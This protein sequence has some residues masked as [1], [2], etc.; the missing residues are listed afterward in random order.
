MISSQE[1]LEVK[2]SD[3]ES[4]IAQASIES[5]TYQLRTDGEFLIEFFLGDALEFPVPQIHIDCWAKMTNLEMERVL[6][7]IPREHAK[8]TLSKLA[9]VWYFLFTTHRFGIYLSNTAP[10]A[11]NACRDILAYMR[12][13]NFIGVFGEIQMIKESETEGLWIF[14]LNLGTGEKKKCILRAAGANQQLRGL[15]IDNQRPDIAVVD[16][17]EDLDNTDSKVLQEKL[18]R[19]IFATF[20]K[21]LAR[22]NKVIWLGNMLRKT[23]LLSR[24][25]QLPYV[26]DS[27]Y[28]NPTVYGC[29]VRD[30]K[31][32]MVPLWPDLWPIN[33]LVADFHQ[34][35]AMGQIET[36]M[37]EMMNQPGVGVNGFTQK[38]LN[39]QPVPTTDSIKG[40]FITID[41]AF[42]MN[43]YLHD[44]TAIVVHVIPEFGPP[45]VVAYEVGRM[46]EDEIFLQALALAREW[47][48]WVWGIESVAAQR[49]FLT[50]FTVYAHNH[51]VKHLLELVPLTAGEAKHAR[52][53]GWYSLMGEELY[54]IPDNDMHITTQILA[55][56]QSKKD[57]VDDLI[58]SCAYGPQMIERYLHLVYTVYTSLKGSDTSPKPTTGVELASA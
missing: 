54:A 12:T 27:T 34:Y 38:G 14:Y 43:E 24:L 30:S 45:M 19:W 48:A 4:T 46:T 3:V 32:K 28:W 5:I 57:N 58:D 7:A 23:S 10:I 42:G 35:A 15:N 8:T 16:D 41:P 39:Y 13:D 20:L 52:I 55:Y 56:D 26:D 9:V 49:L 6:L 31:G 25:S 11:K 37:C 2:Y 29:V 1:K 50:L 18:D 21:A 22:R 53:R 51:R 44:C 17:V 33:K 36:W 47:N 40:A